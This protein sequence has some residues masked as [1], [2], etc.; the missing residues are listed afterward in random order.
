MKGINNGFW[1]QRN[2]WQTAT[3]IASLAVFFSVSQAAAQPLARMGISPD[4][5]EVSFDERG[6]ETQS[7]MVQNF[8]DKP[9]TVKLS[10][11]HWDLDENGRIRVI[12]PHESSL[13]QWIVINPLTV[14]IPPNSPQTIRWAIMP[15]L[16]PKQGEYR[17]IVFIEEDLPPREESE[18][19]QVRMKMRYGLPIYG[20]VGERIQSAEFNGIDVDRDN[21]RLFLDLTNT[22]NSHGR[23]SGNYGIWRVS[24]FPGTQQALSM[25]R[26]AA[27]R[28]V[29]PD[30]FVIASLPGAVILP[31]GRRAIPLDVVLEE[32]GEYILQLNGEFAGL[33]II[34]AINLVQPET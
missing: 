12:A 28:D 6:G 26:A 34:E 5:Y 11:N 7:L 8:G 3:I 4:R 23:M 16:Q 25:L 13:D 24:E 31:E 15:R 20:H 14:T 17:A 33:E 1:L 10:V 32:A 9:I 19:T 21:N 27:V 29:E 2:F 18:G 22:G 30:G